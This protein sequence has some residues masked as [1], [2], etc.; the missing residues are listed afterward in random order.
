MAA[1]S[2][3]NVARFGELPQAAIHGGHANPKR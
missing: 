2:I 3:Q 1:M